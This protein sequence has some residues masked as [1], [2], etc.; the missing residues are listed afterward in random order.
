LIGKKLKINFE[1]QR[2]GGDM[3]IL[4]QILNFLKKYSRSFFGL[5]SSWSCFNK[6]W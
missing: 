6:W 1:I 2:G 5:A 4:L 3:K